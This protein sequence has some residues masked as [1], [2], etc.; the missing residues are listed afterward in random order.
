MTGIERL[1]QLVNKLNEEY[2]PE[3]LLDRQAFKAKNDKS[4]EEEYYELRLSEKFK[5]LQAL[6]TYPKL[7]LQAYFHPEN[8]PVATDEN[9]N[10]EFSI[11]DPY[12][13]RLVPLPGVIAAYLE[14][15]KKPSAMIS[16]LGLDFR[17]ICINKTLTPAKQQS[18]ETF[19]D[20]LE[21]LIPNKNR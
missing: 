20:L 6:S 1:K 21:V 8:V 10:Q 19:L 2:T 15:N 13:Q 11:P 18:F 14:H 4:D 17:N 12:P 5:E 16:Q 9:E 3:D 7:L